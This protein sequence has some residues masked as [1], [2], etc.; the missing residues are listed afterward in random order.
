MNPDM[1]LYPVASSQAQFDQPDP[2]WDLNEP[3]DTSIIDSLPMGL[4]TSYL[5]PSEEAYDYTTDWFETPASTNTSIGSTTATSRSPVDTVK[6]PPALQTSEMATAPGESPKRRGRPAYPS[7]RKSHNE[8]EARYR[9]TINAALK[10]LQQELPDVTGS[11]QRLRGN[12]TKADVM[13]SAAAFIRQLKEENQR[14]WD[15]NERLRGM[16]E[17]KG[18]VLDAEDERR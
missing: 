4:W 12:P 15:G 13:M 5:Q 10:T 14:L 3:G 1:L 2:T 17:R 7:R 9:G 6:T 16:L 18:I 8:I 11:E